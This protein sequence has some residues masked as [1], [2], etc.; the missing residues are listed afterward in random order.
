MMKST[1][2]ENLLQEYKDR[3]GDLPIGEHSIYPSEMFLFWWVAASYNPT[4]IVESGTY[5]GSSTRRLRVLFPACEIITF[6]NDKKNY[7]NA[8]RV[9][10]VD[11]RLGELE[12]NLDLVTPTTVVLIDGPKRKIATRLA[13]KC[14]RK[15]ALCVGIHDM[16]EYI[17]YL[18][19]K[20]SSVVHSG[21]P[22]DTIKELDAGQGV[23]SP[24]KKYYGTTLAVVR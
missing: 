15:G 14:L 23:K 18:E 21:N 1:T 5:L 10:S 24:S 11:Y 12:N 13:R 16:Y 6:D 17:R 2:P 22:L 4:R 9:S 7:K 3:V 8:E 20:F 19:S